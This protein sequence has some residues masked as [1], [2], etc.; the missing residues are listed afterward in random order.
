MTE[1]YVW[2]DI[3]T[4]KFSNSWTDEDLLDDY[5]IDRLCK[6]SLTDDNKDTVK[7]IKFSCVN[8]D[9]FEFVMPMRLA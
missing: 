5:T 2:L 3:A 1:R 8:D 9:D 7:L 4:G 6:E